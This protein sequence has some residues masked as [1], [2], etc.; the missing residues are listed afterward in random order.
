MPPWHQWVGLLVGFGVDARAIPDEEAYR[1]VT[2][3]LVSRRIRYRSGPG[4]PAVTGFVHY[5]RGR[6]GGRG[7]GRRPAILYA[8]SGSR[9]F[10]ELPSRLPHPLYHFVA[11]GFVVLATQYRGNDGGGGREE[12]GGADI[13]DLLSLATLARSLP[14]V[15]GRNLF[16]AGL[17]RGAMMVLL[18]LARGLP[19]RAA[20]VIGAPTDLV[21]DARRDEMTE[22]VYRPLIPGFDADPDGCLRARSALYWPERLTTPLLLIHGADD[23]RVDVS[24]SRRLA[25]EL[26][27]RRHP[28]RLVVVPGGDHGLNGFA[29]RRDRLIID[30][31]KKHLRHR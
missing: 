13:A 30:W 27:R 31:F 29:H 14:V 20:A 24:E 8:R 12:F 6:F 1:D 10:G 28:C 7:G 17:S 18:G 2:S 9:D 4:G 21:T 15:D 25:N 19:V 11:A 16:A 23:D 22:G 3:R 5:R 26:R